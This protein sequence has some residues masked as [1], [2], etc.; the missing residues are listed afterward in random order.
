MS[1]PDF[2]RIEERAQLPVFYLDTGEA[3]FEVWFWHYPLRKWF[4]MS[5]W[6][7]PQMVAHGV[8][9]FH[10]SEVP[11]VFRQRLE[12]IERAAGVSIDRGAKLSA[13]PARLA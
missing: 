11:D 9:Y 6:A 8:I 3:V 7:D 4:C 2:F 10:P 5:A 12:E 13:S 1:R